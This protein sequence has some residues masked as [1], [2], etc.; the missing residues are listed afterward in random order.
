M[1]EAFG[2]SIVLRYKDYF[3]FEIQKK[4]KWIVDDSNNINIGIGC[5]G[6]R[7][8]GDET[9]LEALYR[10]AR[11]EISTS[12][13]IDY[14]DNPFVVSPDF[15]IEGID[16]SKD[17]KIFFYWHGYKGIRI[18]TYYGETLEPPR[19]NDL[20]GVLLVKFETLMKAF[21]TNST[22]AEVVSMG[23]KVIEKDTIPR[24]AYIFPV[25]TV[26]V[27]CKLYENGEEVMNCCY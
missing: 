8:E 17:E 24:E 5:I 23:G 10:E 6:G 9:P 3:V 12:I 19:P 25:G 15:Q 22:V 1:T 2:A 26:E 20:A 7:I 18:C 16:G 14:V 4:H 27:L 21:K 13:T 11:E